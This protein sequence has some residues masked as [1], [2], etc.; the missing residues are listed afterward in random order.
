MRLLRSKPFGRVVHC[1]AFPSPVVRS[2]TESKRLVRLYLR[3]ELPL[4]GEA[5]RRQLCRLLQEWHRQLRVE[6]SE[7]KEGNASGRLEPF[8][9]ID[10]FEYQSAFFDYHLRSGW[11]VDEMTLLG[12]SFDTE[13][14]QSYEIT[15]KPDSEPEESEVRIYWKRPGRAGEPPKS[16]DCWLIKY[17]GSSVTSGGLANALCELADRPGQFR[18]GLVFCSA[19]NLG[20]RRKLNRLSFKW[21]R[22]FRE[23]SLPYRRW[24]NFAEFDSP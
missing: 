6:A 9:D 4:E 15:Y 5:Y 16:L 20:L 10:S 23:R 2:M 7:V 17:D 13:L 24:D 11:N 1:P 12:L 21:E 8:A 18:K 3:L 22:F 14:F 19:Y